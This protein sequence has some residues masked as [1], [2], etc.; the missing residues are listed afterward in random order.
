MDYCAWLMKVMDNSY[1]TGSYDLLASRPDNW[2]QMSDKYGYEYNPDNLGTYE[3]Q[4]DAMLKGAGDED[5]Q[6]L[7]PH[8][9]LHR[10]H[11][12]GLHERRVQK[13]V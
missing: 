10:Q 3:A 5:H 4:R 2:Q 8:R 7:L 6:H 13:C 12:S 1:G 11:P 9:G